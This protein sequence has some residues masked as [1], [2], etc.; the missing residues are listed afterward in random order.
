MRSLKIKLTVFITSAIFFVV[1]LFAIVL[2][3]ATVLSTQA[4]ITREDL[5]RFAS[6]RPEIEIFIKRH[7]EFEKVVELGE[8]IKEEQRIVYAR[9]LFLL[10]PPIILLSALGSYGVATLFLRPIE[11]V[12]ANIR[13]MGSRNLSQ[14][15]PEI[16]SS[17]EVEFLVKAFNALMNELEE[18]FIA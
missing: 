18:A 2:Y 9:T 14:R 11:E 7:K 13:L 5:E 4:P 1:S 16:E 10:L 3:I 6:K 8:E 17:E 15:I 12:T